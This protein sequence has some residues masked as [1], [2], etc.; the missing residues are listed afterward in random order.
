M[1][2][3]GNRATL[4]SRSWPTHAL[5]EEAAVISE[6]TALAVADGFRGIA[7]AWDVGVNL[8]DRTHPDGL[9]AQECG[10]YR[11]DVRSRRRIRRRPRTRDGQLGD[12]DRS[13]TP[14]RLTRDARMHSSSPHDFPK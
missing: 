13:L 11:D 12:I 8:P 9:C 3:H 1:N 4:D 10:R 5:R 7:E 6:I 14:A 2:D